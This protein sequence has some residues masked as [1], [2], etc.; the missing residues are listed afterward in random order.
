MISDIFNIISLDHTSFSPPPHQHAS[1]MTN[2]ANEIL[3][4]IISIQPKDIVGGEGET[5]ESCIYRMAGE[6]LERLPH[7]Y[8]QHQVLPFA[9]VF[10]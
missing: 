6:M 10:N 7:P 8:V 4:G 2:Q 1:Y 3:D 9:R 5:R